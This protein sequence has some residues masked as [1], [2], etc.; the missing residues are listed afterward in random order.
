[1]LNLLQG[2]REANVATRGEWVSSEEPLDPTPVT[3]TRLTLAQTDPGHPDL[4]REQE[5]AS[6]A[7]Y[8]SASVQPWPGM[9]VNPWSNEA[10]GGSWTQQRLFVDRTGYARLCKLYI[11]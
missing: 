4:T 3:P 11:Q 1:M 5:A 6:D 7:E 8:L 2:Q 10:E 9:A